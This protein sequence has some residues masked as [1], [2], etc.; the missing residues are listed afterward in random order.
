M[1]MLTSTW[2]QVAASIHDFQTSTSSQTI[3]L[4]PSLCKETLPPNVRTHART[5]TPGYKAPLP[6]D[7]Q[8]AKCPPSPN[9]RAHTHWSKVP[10]PPIVHF[11]QI[12]T[13]TPIWVQ[14]ATTTKLPP[15]PNVYAHTHL[16]EGCCSLQMADSSGVGGE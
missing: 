6:P 4:T 1:L 9:V 16:G 13:L 15:S 8:F 5:H 11:L 14:G 7:V 3:E 10:D 2:V 12:F